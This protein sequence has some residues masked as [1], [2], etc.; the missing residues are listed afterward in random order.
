M[1]ILKIEKNLIEVKHN[2]IDYE[3]VMFNY[4]INGL[5]V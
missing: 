1:K 3:F 5:H 2:G 4:I